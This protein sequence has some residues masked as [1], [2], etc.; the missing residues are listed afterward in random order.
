[1]LAVVP[2]G[3]DR[4]PLAVAIRSHLLAHFTDPSAGEWMA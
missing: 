2:P 4:M 1:V 3:L